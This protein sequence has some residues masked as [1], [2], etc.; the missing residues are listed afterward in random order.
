MFS[1][2]DCPANTVLHSF[3]GG[4][5][6]DTPTRTSIQIAKNWH[7][8]DEVGS[9]INHSCSPSTFI[10]GFFIIS[11]RDLKRDEEITFD[12]NQNE[13]IVSSPFECSCCG[14]IITGRNGKKG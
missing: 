1:R 7:I 6:A 13:D 2:T 4:E 12:Y 9:C 5:L 8:E 14:K 11:A 3:L 10:E